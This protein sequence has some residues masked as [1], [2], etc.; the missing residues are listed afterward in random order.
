[1]FCCDHRARVRHPDDC[2][3][4]IQDDLQQCYHWGCSVISAGCECCLCSGRQRSD[5]YSQTACVQLGDY[6]HSLQYPPVPATTRPSPQNFL[7][8]V[9]CG[10]QCTRY[11][12]YCPTAR[13]R[14]S[15]SFM[16]SASSISCFWTGQARCL[17]N[18]HKCDLATS[19]LCACGQRRNF[20]LFGSCDLDLNPMTFISELDPHSLGKY[21][22]S[23][24]GLPSSNLQGFRKLS[25]D[26]QTDRQT[27]RQGQNY[28]PRRF[29][30]GQ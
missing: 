7:T 15:S 23:E 11:R 18:L 20:D 6:T 25:S 1:M 5:R 17:A 26:T 21:R 13:I 24:Y 3:S 12:L 19:D 29:A 14:S 2:G 27:D 4:P 9:L 10:Q 30:G 28:T 22:M 8:T 16:V